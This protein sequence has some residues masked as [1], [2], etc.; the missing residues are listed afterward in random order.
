MGGPQAACKA[1]DR[2]G[3]LNPVVVDPVAAERIGIHA[4]LRG[5]RPGGVR[6]DT[7]NEIVDVSRNF[8]RQS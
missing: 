7:C 3:S 8:Y 6:V 1:R 2:D 5:P 4:L